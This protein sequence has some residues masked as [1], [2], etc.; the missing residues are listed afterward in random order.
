ME[1]DYEMSMWIEQRL[2]QRI[3]PI[4][5]GNQLNFR[6][7]ICGDSRKN[8]HKKRCYFYK[9]GNGSLHCFNCDRTLQGLNIITEL[10]HREYKDVRLE[11]LQDKYGGKLPPWKPD[12]NIP[13]IPDIEI[14]VFDD[15]LPESVVEYLNNRKIFDAPAL[16]ENY[17]FKFNKEKNRLVIP[18]YNNGVI[19]YYQERILNNKSTL[20]YIFPKIPKGVFNIDMVDPTFP[21]IF[22][23]EGVFDAIFVKNGI[24]IGGQN[25]S[26]HQRSIIK[27]RWPNHKIVYF[28]DNIYIEP[29][30]R[31]KILKIVRNH[32]HDMHLLWPEQLIKIKDINDWIVLG[33]T[34]VFYDMDWLKSHISNSLKTKI[35]TK[36]VNR[37]N[38]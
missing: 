7:F 21:Y 12:K 4:D 37:I 28:F 8:K 1:C 35:I 20:K 10:E 15:I 3:K 16:P 18:W 14:P 27:S 29:K 30:T 38:E 13:K 31:Q 11:Y 32:P 6:C 17:K 22:V 24:A 9:S 25:L 19:N 36:N 2:K 23:L 26:S 5:Q 34:N 33:G